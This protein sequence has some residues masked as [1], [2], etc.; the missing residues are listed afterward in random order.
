[1]LLPTRRSFG[2]ELGRWASALSVWLCF[3]SVILDRV[4][5][6]FELFMVYRVFR[7]EIHSPLLLAADEMLIGSIAT[8]RHRSQVHF[9]AGVTPAALEGG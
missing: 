2:G 8:S 7:P 3:E 1:M 4:C 6:C 5:L 9:T